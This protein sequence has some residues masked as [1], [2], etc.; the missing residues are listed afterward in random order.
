MIA[1]RSIR[2]PFLV[3]GVLLAS[4]P[5]GIHTPVNVETSPLS[6]T[7]ESFLIESGTMEDSLSVLRR[8]NTTKILI[9]FEKIARRRDEKERAISLSVVNST[10][11]EILNDLCRQDADYTYEVLG[12]SLIHVYPKNYQSD[13]AGLLSLR[14]S[15]FS[16]VAKM[17]PAA[18]IER[19]GELAPELESYM[20]NKQ[21]EFYAQRGL[22]PPGSPGSIMSGNMDPQI[23]LDLENMTVRELLNAVVLYSR[24]LRE[25]TPA[26][27]GGYKT[28]PT[29]WAYEFIIDPAAPT[30]LAGTPHWKAF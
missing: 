20:S 1:T 16:I 11:G 13:P 27:I 4:A 25:Q 24:Q 30:G 6:E 19:I 10:V 7:V 28:P 9:G 18:I 5:G 29:S 8:T 21:A 17:L 3:M 12:G 2:L 14:I 26:G 22:A 15:R 23:N